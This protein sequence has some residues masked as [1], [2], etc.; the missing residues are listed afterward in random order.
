MQKR[1][2]DAL[3]ITYQPFAGAF[4]ENAA[5]LLM[6]Y[7][8]IARGD[9]A[10]LHHHDALEVGY[11]ESGS[12]IFIVDGERLP[13]AAP[14]AS[15]IYPG[16]V[17]IACGAGA[18]ECRWLFVTFQVEG[19]FA[20]ERFGEAQ[21]PWRR[22]D[23][24]HAVSTDPAIVQLAAEIELE[25]RRH[26]P[27]S[28]EC[29]RGLLAVLLVRHARL[30]WLAEAAAPRGGLFLPQLNPLLEYIGRYYREPIWVEELAARAFVHPTTLRSWFRTAV[31]MTPTEYVHC[32]RITAAASLLRTTARPITEIAF[33]VGYD[34]LSSFGRHFLSLHGCTPTEYRRAGAPDRAKMEKNG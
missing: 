21:L 31:G 19:V 11:C 5:Q 27:G 32:I 8:P 4:R 30:P 13:F 28:S 20:A 16:Q 33:A 26:A 22:A 29:I 9:A 24:R 15:V 2:S 23:P 18:M 7:A 14:C 34:S 1:A 3:P 25:Y 10:F 17:H 12:G 6:G